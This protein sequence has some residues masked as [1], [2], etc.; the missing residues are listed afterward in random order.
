MYSAA[1]NNMPELHGRS[2]FTLVSSSPLLLSVHRDLTDQEGRKPRSTYSITQLH[3]SES[4]FHNLGLQN[5]P[6]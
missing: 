6:Q 4:L 3:S 5:V 2:I 1:L